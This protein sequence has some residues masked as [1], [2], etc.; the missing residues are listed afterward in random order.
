MECCNFKEGDNII[1][2]LEIKNDTNEDAILPSFLEVL[3]LDVFNVY[4]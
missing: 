2:S 1:F 3:G 4:S